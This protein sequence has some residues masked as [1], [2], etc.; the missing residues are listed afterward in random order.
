M[1][2]SFTAHLAINAEAWVLQFNFDTA[3]LRYSVKV[4]NK[5]EI[6][7]CTM[8]MI[9]HYFWKIIQGSSV[10]LKTAEHKL[11]DLIRQYNANL[12]LQ[13]ADNTYASAGSQSSADV[14][15]TY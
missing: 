12:Y 10:E 14:L 15:S 6:E 3:L 2:R 4:L 13:L 8:A 9:S 5:K 1:F 7:T 11:N